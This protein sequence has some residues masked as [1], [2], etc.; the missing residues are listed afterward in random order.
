MEQHLL[1][2]LKIDYTRLKLPLKSIK[3]YQLEHFL[4]SMINFERYKTHQMFNVA[5]LFKDGF[6]QRPCT[7]NYQVNK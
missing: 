2:Y 5:G 4:N 6:I 7:F 1:L 3:A